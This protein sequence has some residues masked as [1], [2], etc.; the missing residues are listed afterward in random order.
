MGRVRLPDYRQI[1]GRDVWGKSQG[2]HRLEENALE[3]PLEKAQQTAQTLMSSARACT[4]SSKRGRSSSSAD[5]YSLAQAYTSQRRGRV[6]KH[7]GFRKDSG[8]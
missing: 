1:R 2:Q 7:L 8:G 5:L 3:V 6:G 4:C